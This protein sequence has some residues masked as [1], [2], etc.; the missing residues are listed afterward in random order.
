MSDAPSLYCLTY[1]SQASR[2]VHEVTP[3]PLLRKAR[4][5]HQSV[6]LRSLLRYANGQFLHVPED[7]EPALSTLYARIRADPRH[8]AVRTLACGPVVGRA[9]P[10]WHVAHAPT[11][12]KLIEK[13]LGFLPLAVVLGPAASPPAAVSRLLREFVE[14][15]ARHR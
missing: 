15:A 9:F 4:R 13:V 7:P 1:R 2:A 8:F 11:D 5:H 12:Q 3:P 10:D 14:D 6:N